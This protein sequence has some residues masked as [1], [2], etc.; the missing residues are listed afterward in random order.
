MSG[1]KDQKERK[2]ASSVTTFFSNKKS[3]QCKVAS[4]TIADTVNLWMEQ[5]W[6][7]QER[8]PNRQNTVLKMNKF[9]PQKIASRMNTKKDILQKH[10]VQN[11]K[12]S[13]PMNVKHYH[14]KLKNQKKRRCVLQRC[15]NWR[16][17]HSQE[18][19]LVETTNLWQL[20]WDSSTPA[21]IR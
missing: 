12:I 9:V 10:K 2:I 6:R 11:Q 13:T 14:N 17:I 1:S 8:W 4:A 7:H 18:Q 19:K 21:Q 3:S 16:N 5:Q 20:Y 15:Q